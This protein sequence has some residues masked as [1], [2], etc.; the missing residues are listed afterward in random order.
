MDEDYDACDLEN[1]F[2]AIQSA[3][4]QVVIPSFHRPAIIRIDP[5]T[6][7]TTGC[8]RTSR[9]QWRDQLWA[10]SA[11]RILRPCQA[12][13]HDAS[14]FKDLRPDPTTGQITY[15]VDND[16]DGKPDSVWVDLGYPA[17]RDASGRL[18]K[19]LFAFM[20]IGLNGRIPL[21]TAGNLADFTEA[22]GVNIPSNANTGSPLPTPTPPTYY[23]GP[24]H[25]HAPGQFGQRG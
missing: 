8:G 15:D 9:T 25:A 3:D 18:Y 17:R 22:S 14:T 21:N 24:T 16:G 19:P 5:S 10:D 7:R 2:L 13:G 1:W 20:V 11:A 6:T 4:G 12:D 23:G